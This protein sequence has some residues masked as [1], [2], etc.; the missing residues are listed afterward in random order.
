MKL[1]FATAILLVLPSPPAVALSDSSQM[2]HNCNVSVDHRRA[3]DA[4]YAA[5][6]SCMFYIDGFVSGYHMATP[7]GAR[8]FCVPRGVNNGQLV[9]VYSAWLN[10]HPEKLHEPKDATAVWALMDA[11][12]CGSRAVPKQ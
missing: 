1:R 10:K 6:F 3:S 11:F 2:A 12:P 8:S 7:P 9:R 4:D 5:S